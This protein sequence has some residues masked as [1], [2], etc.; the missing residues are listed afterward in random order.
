M[1]LDAF[2]GRQQ[3]STTNTGKEDMIPTP[4]RPTTH[5]NMTYHENNNNNSIRSGGRSMAS[6]RTSLRS[7]MSRADSYKSTNSG[8]SVR[9]S[10]WYMKHL[11]PS[12]IFS[13]DESH[14]DVHHTP[15][16]DDKR[17]ST[18]TR[19][20]QHPRTSVPI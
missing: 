15:E 8:I 11:S 7:T 10:P 6:C 13:N 19:S 5:P 1:L 17:C 14:S 3:H 2:A 20:N 9:S 12:V 16:R 4:L 18:V